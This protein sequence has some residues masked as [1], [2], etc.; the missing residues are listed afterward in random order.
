[1]KEN[2]GGSS[3]IR[4]E[5][6]NACRA[7]LAGGLRSRTARLATLGSQAALAALVL[8]PATQA[9]A[10]DEAP[11]KASTFRFEGTDLH[12]GEAPP[13]SF[14]GFLSQGFLYSSD[15]NYL[16]KSTDGS[17]EF[18]EIG[19]N[20]AMNPFPKTRIAVQGFAFDVG[21]VGNLIPFLDYGSIEYTF[22]DAIALRGGR[23]RRPGGLY[24]HIQDV[25]LARTAVL[26]PQGVYDARWRDFSSS[27]DGGVAFGS[28]SLGKAG[29]ISY[30]AY[31]GVT[32]MDPENGGVAAWIT[33]G[34]PGAEITEFD[35]PLYA[36]G[37][38]WYN[39]PVSGLR[40]G[41]NVGNMFDFGYHLTTP[42]SPVGPFGPVN[43][44]THGTGDVFFQQYSAEYLWNDW[45]F[46]AEYYTWDF[47]GANTTTVLS[48]STQIQPTSVGPAK[49]NPYAWYAS[50]AYRVNSWMEVGTYYTQYVADMAD[51]KTSSPNSFQNDL[52]LSFRFDPTDWWILKVEGHY[53]EGTA[54][55]RDQANNPNAIRTD[56]P[57]FMLAL[58]TT[59]YF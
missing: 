56:D 22:N 31:A 23:V 44:F 14:H 24:N 19:I 41:A 57:W 10:Q 48:G 7:A 47:D 43:A 49:V 21:E 3:A 58:K 33:D 18:T 17:F 36:G 52:A 9:M 8:Q 15:Y 6:K 51:G 4:N 37:Q 27:I 55:L 29:G 20:A 39:T 26:L 5:I 50:A 38:L 2:H 32:N 42:V 25:D 30:E 53:L 46:Q 1:M 35:Q 11:A 12:I 45:T 59:F 54:L 28:F 16:G 13:I 40:V 34:S